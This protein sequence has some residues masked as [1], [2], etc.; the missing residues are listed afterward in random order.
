MCTVTINIDEATMRQ[1]N[2]NLTSRESI[3][4]WLQHRVDMMIEEI[5]SQN[6]DTMDVEELRL[7]LHE[8][9]RKEYALP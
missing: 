1:I 4:K 5:V 3:G 6:A 2:P 8:T 7:M 9:V